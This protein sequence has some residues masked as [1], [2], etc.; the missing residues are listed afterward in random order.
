[1][2]QCLSDARILIDFVGLQ[3]L[4]HY[5]VQL[6]H[7]PAVNLKQLVCRHGVQHR[8]EIVQIA[9]GKAQRIPQ[10]PVAGGGLFHQSIANAHIGEIIREADP[11]AQ[12][13]RPVLF[14][15][16]LRSDT[17]HLRFGHFAA[18]FVQGPAICD[19]LLVRSSAPSGNTDHQRG[20]K[21]TP[22]LVA[23]FEISISRVGQARPLFQ[24][25]PA[26]RA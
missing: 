14:D 3:A 17:I 20:V 25:R 23:P 24:N 26:G 18:L 10:C 12:N 19:N 5:F 16:C 15:D 4:V 8:V 22:V 9:E 2:Q 1:M 21:P 7:R 13:I 6:V 11:E